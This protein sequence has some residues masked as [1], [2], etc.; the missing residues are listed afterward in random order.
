VPALVGEA[1]A[2]LLI[3]DENPIRIAQTWRE[4]VANSL[5][6]PF[7][8]V[9]ADVVVPTSLFPHEEF[10]ARTL[11]PKVHRVLEQY[12]KPLPAPK[13]CID[14]NKP[15]PAGEVI[16]PD[17]LLA[18]LEVGGA[19]EVPGYRGGTREAKRRLN[20]FLRERLDHYAADRNEPVPYSTTE[21]SA[22]LHFG[23]ISPLSI[24][25]EVQKSDAPRQNVDALL[26][27]LVVRRELAINFV[28][29]NPQYDQLAGCPEWARKTLAAHAADPRP[30]LY[31]AAQLEAAETHDPLWN[32]AQKE[33]VLTGRMHNYLRMYWAKKFLEWTPDAETAF[34]IAV[35]LNDRYEMDGRDPNGYTGI[36]WAIGGKHDRPWP[37]RPIFGTVRYMSYESTRR[38]FHSARYIAWVES[39]QNGQPRYGSVE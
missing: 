10:A 23:H 9:D 14:W 27:E 8:L 22:H 11:R 2:S 12:L 35:D 3:G 1:D 16:E 33:M 7:Y 32:A 34:E 13:A 19:A 4:Q 36:A 26:E 38:K 39:I 18:R 25:L 24:A 31:S 20:R 37:E 28:A 21:L 17:V 5:K 15:V 6:I 29:R 30:V